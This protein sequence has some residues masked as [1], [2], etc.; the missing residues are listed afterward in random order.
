[1]L[2]REIER[3]LTLMVSWMVKLVE[4]ILFLLFLAIYIYIA[5]LSGLPVSGLSIPPQVGLVTLLCIGLLSGMSSGLI[6]WGWRQ[7]D[8]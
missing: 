1:M 5:K 7:R 3:T 8:R 2:W 4:L 6:M